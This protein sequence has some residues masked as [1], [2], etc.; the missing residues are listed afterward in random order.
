MCDPCW[1]KLKDAIKA[2]G[3]GEMVSEHGYHAVARIKDQAARGATKDNYDPLASAVGMI[4]SNAIE[5][6]GI[7]ILMDQPD[8]KELCPI[9]ALK[10]PDWIEKAADG[11]KGM[12]DRLNTPPPV[13]GQNS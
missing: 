12:A 10:V 3:L 2:R 11:A 6:G 1:V 4:Y 13:S 7:A 9:C 8:G 5:A